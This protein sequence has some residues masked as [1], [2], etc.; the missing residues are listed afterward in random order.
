MKDYINSW[1]PIF[2]TSSSICVEPL[3]AKGLRPIYEKVH[4]RCTCLCPGPIGLEPMTLEGERG[5]LICGGLQMCKRTFPLG[6]SVL[7][8]RSAAY[9]LATNKNW[10]NLLSGLKSDKN[11]F[12]SRVGNDRYKLPNSRFSSWLFDPSMINLSWPPRR[13]KI[14]KHQVNKYK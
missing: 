1:K 13:N 9:V 11:F 5:A 12:C 10:T 4:R 3:A 2:E 14:R 7:L 8:L 6:S